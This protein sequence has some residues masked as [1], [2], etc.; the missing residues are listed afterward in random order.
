MSIWGYRLTSKLIAVGVLVVLIGTLAGVA[1]I[2]RTQDREITLVARG[3]AFYLLGDPT[4]PNPTITLNAGERVRIVLRNDD[5][6]MTHDFA[7]PAVDAA[8]DP[9]DWNEDEDVTFDVPTTPGRYE[10]MCRPHML[11]MRGQIIVR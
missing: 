1:A 11:M 4:T 8:L 7:V 9:I 3:M 5:R 2:T 10:Y 6:G